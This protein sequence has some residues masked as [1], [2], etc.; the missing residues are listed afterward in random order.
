[1]S[2]PIPPISKYMTTTPITIEPEVTIAAASKVMR[3]SRIRH[4]PVTRAGA[5]VGI[6]SERDVYL[7]ETLKGVDAQ[8][9]T[10]EDAMTH[11]PYTTVPER[12]VNEVAAEMAEHKYGAAIIL[13]NNKVVG[14][15]TTVDACAM[16]AELFETR[17]K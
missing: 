1:M 15:F 17:L 11:K 3:E 2:K 8:T 9:V 6:L 7:I 13:Q 10:V 14:V 12:P 4:L 5:L 16:L